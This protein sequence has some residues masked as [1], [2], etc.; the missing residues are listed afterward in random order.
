MTDKQ[1]TT[2]IYGEFERMVHQILGEEEIDRLSQIPSENPVGP[3]S[4]TVSRDELNYVLAYL[5]LAKSAHDLSEEEGQAFRY[6]AKIAIRKASKKISR[7]RRLVLLHIATCNSAFMQQN[8]P[9][10]LIVLF[11]EDQMI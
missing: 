10:F 4:R 6:F 2:F 5:A 3:G 9:H 1:N 8:L 11:E 7:N